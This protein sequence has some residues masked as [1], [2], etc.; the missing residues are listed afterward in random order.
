V[1]TDYCYNSTDNSGNFAVGTASIYSDI[2]IYAEDCS[3]R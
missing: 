1:A 2:A 3:Q